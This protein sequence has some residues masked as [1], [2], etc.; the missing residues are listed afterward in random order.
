MNAIE[1]KVKDSTAAVADTGATLFNTKYLSGGYLRKELSLVARADGGTCYLVIDNKYSAGQGMDIW[2]SSDGEGGWDGGDVEK[3]IWALPDSVGLTAGNHNTV[4]ENYVYLTYN[5]G[6]PALKRHGA[7]DQ[8]GQT[9][10]LLDSMI[11]MGSIGLGAVSGSDEEIRY[12]GVD[13][14]S[15]YKM[16]L[17]ITL[18]GWHAQYHVGV[19]ITA[20][21]HTFTHLRGF[22][23]HGT[24][25][26]LVPAIST[27]DVYLYVPVYADSN[28]AQ[29]DSLDN[30]AEFSNGDPITSAHHFWVVIW[31]AVS[32]DTTEYKV[33]MN[34]QDGTNK[35]NTLSQA[36]QDIKKMM[37]TV[38]PA[39]FH[40]TGFLIAAMIIK[41]SNNEIQTLTDGSTF[42]DLR[43]L[44]SGASGGAGAPPTDSLQ[45]DAW[46]F[47][48]QYNWLDSAASN[49]GWGLE[50]TA[51]GDDSLRVKAA[52]LDQ[53]YFTEAETQSEISDSLDEYVLTTSL[54]DSL[55]AYLIEAAV[56]AEI[57][58][59]LDEYS[60]TASIEVLIED[61]LN[62]YL[63]TGAVQSE[64]GDSLAEYL[65]R[66]Q[67]KDS[68]DA[69]NYL[70]STNIADQGIIPD[71][72]D[73]T[74][75]DFVFSSVYR[76]MSSQAESVFVTI[77]TIEDS[78][79]L[80]HKYGDT[81][82]R[83]FV[84]AYPTDAFDFPFWQTKRAIT[85][86]AVSAI[87][88]SGTNVIGALDEYDGAASGVDA[89]VDG[90]W[91]VTTSE[92]TDASFSNPALDAGDWLGWHTTSVSG[93]VVTFSITFEYTE[94]Y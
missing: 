65:E 29:W 5:G 54:E 70:D 93:E 28:Y 42:R 64:I 78:L 48:Y 89:A 40:E 7:E 88:K 37:P 35:Y 16:P 10:E 72:I 9:G 77:E 90:D 86:V 33:Y 55:D 17:R 4:A 74:D 41:G 46:N 91:T 30:F 71:D 36:E 11:F 1:I 87:C 68:L 19:D 20:E 2:L 62:G 3:Y 12:F 94:T 6:S 57:E 47:G 66:V 85:I 76:G 34:I 92:Y 75:N 27:D 81:L 18:H 21:S 25:N 13:Q 56:Q 52:D 79:A 38:I 44:V 53:R 39:T 26:N 24:D 49:A 22:L 31:G 43:G 59:S 60:T 15:L 69:A 14:P 63:T 80:R 84:I 50:T 73:T 51:D 83:A 61:S 82:S 58:D 32:K 8:I 23:H 45:I 67:F